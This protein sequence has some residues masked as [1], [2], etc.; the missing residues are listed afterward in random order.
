MVEFGVNE[1]VTTLAELGIRN[2]DILV[3]DLES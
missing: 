3:L 2:G 1:S